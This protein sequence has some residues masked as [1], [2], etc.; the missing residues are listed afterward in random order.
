MFAFSHHLVQGKAL[1]KAEELST[2]A[3]F[4]A[5]A[6]QSQDMSDV[7][8][9]YNLHAWQTLGGKACVLDMVELAKEYDTCVLYQ[10]R[11]VNALD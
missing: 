3:V 7:G 2:E 6:D 9:L 10:L 5:L 11:Y 1:L 8:T 4:L